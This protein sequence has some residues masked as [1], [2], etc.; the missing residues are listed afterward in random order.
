MGVLF[1]ILSLS[2]FRKVSRLEIKRANPRMD[3]GYYECRAMNAVAREPAVLHTRVIV[4]SGKVPTP[5]SPSSDT[6]DAVIGA[7][8]SRTTER[9]RNRVQLM[10]TTSPN[11]NSPWYEHPCPRPTYCLNAGQCIYIKPLAEYYCKWVQRVKN[12]MK[13]NKRT[14]NKQKTRIR[15]R[16][17]RSIGFRDIHQTAR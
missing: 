12:K 16:A 15:K 17:K 9:G 8:N 10:S 11:I 7:G 2:L 13:R 1:M 3:T 6:A 14:S 5:P 4:I